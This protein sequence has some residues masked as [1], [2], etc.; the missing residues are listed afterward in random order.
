[1]TDG[2][3]LPHYNRDQSI[4]PRCRADTHADRVPRSWWI[5]LLFGWLPLKRYM[6]YKCKRKYY[7]ITKVGSDKQ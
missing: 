6:C 3:N 5:K 4:C 1:M 2:H 7:I